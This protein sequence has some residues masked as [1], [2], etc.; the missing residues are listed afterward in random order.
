MKIRKKG[1][2]KSEKRLAEELLNRNGGLL[3]GAFATLREVAANNVGAPARGRKECLDALV[4]FLQRIQAYRT[5]HPEQRFRSLS[6]YELVRVT[7]ERL[8]R[9][10]IT[11]G[12]HIDEKT[13][14]D[15]CKWLRLLR[16]DKNMSNYTLPEWRWIIKRSTTANRE[17]GRRKVFQML[18]SLRE[19]RIREHLKVT[20]LSAKYPDQIP[21]LLRDLPL[22]IDQLISHFERVASLYK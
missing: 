2:T 14:R 18:E 12:R 19:R 9:K 5:T 16:G 1:I 4:P 6:Q 20:E 10:G 22:H 8:Q 15:T 21:P 11:V 7:K 3:K 13:I 17:E